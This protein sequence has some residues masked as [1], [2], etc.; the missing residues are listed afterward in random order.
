MRRHSG[1]GFLKTRKVPFSDW[2]SAS[3]PMTQKKALGHALLDMPT[4]SAFISKKEIRKIYVRVVPSTES[5]KKPWR[6]ISPFTS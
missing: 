3:N 2:D 5:P 1:I 6:Q 4:T